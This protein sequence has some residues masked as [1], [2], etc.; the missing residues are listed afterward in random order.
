MG[1]VH[2]LA[3][4]QQE[5]HFGVRHAGRLDQILD[6]GADGEPSLY[7]PVAVARR[8][9]VVELRV[10]TECRL[11]HVFSGAALA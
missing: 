6:R 11:R 3:V 7:W 10:E 8:Q 5:I 2:R 1:E 4:D 9:E